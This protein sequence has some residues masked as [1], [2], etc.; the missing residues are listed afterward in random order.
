MK[1]LRIFFTIVV[2]LAAGIIALPFVV[3]PEVITDQ[4][5][6]VTKQQTGRDL[7]L[8][9]DASFSVSPYR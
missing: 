7:T 4:I 2:L 1:F 5:V 6:R 9:G 8:G 3:P